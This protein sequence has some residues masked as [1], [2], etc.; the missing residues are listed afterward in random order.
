MTI[1]PPIPEIQFDLK[2]SR[3]KVKVK[4]T[5]VSAASCW[6][7]SLVFY[8]RASYWLPPL[9]FHD[10]RASHSWGTIWPWKFKVKGQGQRYPSQCS[11]QLTH[12]L[13]VSHQGFLLNN[14]PFVPWQSGLPFPIYNLTLKF[15]AKGQGQRYPSQH[16]IQLINFLSVSHQLDQPFLRY[17]KYNVR[18][19]KTDLKVYAKI[20]KKKVQAEFFQNLIRW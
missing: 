14:I 3:S 18:L 11:V 6:L 4:S 12:F 16:S 9:L 13:S 7:I 10:N 2:N 8:I 17:G 20:T 19:Q 15:K 5:P 1:R